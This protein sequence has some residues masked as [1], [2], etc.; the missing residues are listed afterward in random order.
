MYGKF[1]PYL[2]LNEIFRLYNYCCGK[3]QNSK[4]NGQVGKV[5]WKHFNIITLFF[6]EKK[7]QRK[8]NRKKKT[9]GCFYHTVQGKRPLVAVTSRHQKHK[10]CH[11]IYG[12]LLQVAILHPLLLAV[13]QVHLVSGSQET[14]PSRGRYKNALL[15]SKFG[16][17]VFYFFFLC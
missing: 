14:T 2:K 9:I 6:K 1:S 13:F 10:D 11:C 3:H 5:F 15:I 12:N 4:K 16:A 17:F 8:G 7:S